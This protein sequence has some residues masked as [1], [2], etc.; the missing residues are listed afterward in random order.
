MFRED[1]SDAFKIYYELVDRFLRCCR[2]IRIGKTFFTGD[3]FG[4]RAFARV[5]SPW[6]APR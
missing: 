6:N 4:F 2:T 3:R 1:P 5:V